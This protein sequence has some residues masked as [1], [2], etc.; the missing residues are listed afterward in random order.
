MTKRIRT[1]SAEN[2]STMNMTSAP[3]NPTNDGKALAPGHGTGQWIN[4]RA[5][6]AMGL[7]MLP[8]ARA[9]AATET[10]PETTFRRIPTQ[11]IAALGKP[12]AT[13]GTGA[14]NWGWWYK[15][16][17]PRGVW[18]VRYNDLIAAG[19]VAPARWKFD[20]KDWWLDENGLIMEK[21]DFDISPGKYVVTGNRETVAV[22]TIHPKDFSGDMRWEL[23]QGATL[24]DVTHLR[25]RSARYTP[26]TSTETC[27]PDKVSKAAFPVRR[28]GPMPEVAGCRMQDYTVVFVIGVAVDSS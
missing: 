3:G 11:F 24:H 1:F 21:P 5:A 18:L 6:L 9:L 14:Q 27:T 28:G 25:C 4:R 22:L 17:G 10:K 2:I 12:E 8:A 23:D 7:L 13:S 16:P 19:G 15:D 26:A 20:S